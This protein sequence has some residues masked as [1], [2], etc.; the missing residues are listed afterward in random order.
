MNL[1]PVR[2]SSESDGGGNEKGAHSSLPSSS[3]RLAALDRGV[4]KGRMAEYHPNIINF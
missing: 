1:L 2:C 3:Q 4:H